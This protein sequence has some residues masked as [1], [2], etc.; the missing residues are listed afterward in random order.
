MCSLGMVTTLLT[1]LAGRWTTHLN[2]EH[3][4]GAKTTPAW[5]PI[6]PTL[7]HAGDCSSSII[8]A[9]FLKFQALLPRQEKKK[10]KTPLGKH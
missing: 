4:G 6:G 2:V 10:K 3:F 8:T 5:R 7:P 9:L 1:H